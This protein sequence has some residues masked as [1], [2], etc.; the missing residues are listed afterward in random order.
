MIGWLG[1]AQA[2][3]GDPELALSTIDEGLQ[4]INDIAGRAWEAELRRLCA[5]IL[6]MTRPDAINEAERNYK[7]AIAIAQ[8]QRARSLELRATTSLARLLQRLGRSEEAR[9][10]LAGVR[11][12]FT[13]GFDTADIKDA[14]ALLETLGKTA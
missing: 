4:G 6:L 2:E 9:K 8:K 14:T 11:G 3:N 10:Y 1:T 5:N 12:W 7:E 13:E